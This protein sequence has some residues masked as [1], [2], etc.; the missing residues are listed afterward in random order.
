M[1]KI[2]CVYMRGGTSKGL[3][4]Q[5]KDLPEDKFL[6]P[7]IFM[8]AMGTP[9][10]KQIDGMGGGTSSTSKIA[11]ISPSKRP[12][13][14]VDYNFFQVDIVIPNVDNTANCGNLLAAVGSFAVEEGLVPAVE[15]E[16]VVRVFNTNTQKLIEVRV[17][18]ENGRLKETG[19]AKVEGVPGTAA[20]IHVQFFEP[21]GTKTGKLFPTGRRRDL[22]RVPGYGEE[23][24]TLIDCANPVVF[25]NARTLG[26]RGTELTELNGDHRVMDHIEAIRGVAAEKLGFVQ[27][28]REASFKSTSIPKVG[29]VSSPQEY[30]DL[31]GGINRREQMDLCVR[32]VSIGAIHKAIPLTVAAA[33]CVAAMLKGTVVN[34]VTAAHED[35][36][37]IRLGHASGVTTVSAQIEGEDRVMR[38]G[39]VRTARRIMDG[40]VYV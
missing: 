16:T 38:A 1:M 11:V 26:I 17:P 2:P 31:G 20:P 29:I 10:I 19:S 32:A 6:W 15:P 13:A 5:E 27:D 23:E 4:F 28:W 3:F 22:F 36:D 14:D 18:I 25:V 33:T 24:V 37:Q 8:R 39:M 35:T 9:D 40:F 12:D 30:K 34:D 7:G 21:A